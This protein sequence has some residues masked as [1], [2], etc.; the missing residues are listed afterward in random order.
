MVDGAEEIEKLL[1]EYVPGPFIP[2]YYISPSGSF[3]V[4]FKGDADYSQKLTNDITLYRSME[5]DEVVGV[6]VE[7]K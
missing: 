5:T 6:R 4:Y 1:K 3:T 7:A 2:H